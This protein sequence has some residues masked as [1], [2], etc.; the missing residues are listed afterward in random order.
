[1]QDG[2]IISWRV[3]PISAASSVEILSFSGDMIDKKVC[4]PTKQGITGAC[5]WEGIVENQ[6]SVG[7]FNYIITLSI[8]GKNMSFNPFIKIV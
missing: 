1:M 8:E 7:Q 2:Q 6:G 5:F 4:N 3:V